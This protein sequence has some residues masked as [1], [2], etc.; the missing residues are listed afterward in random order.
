MTPAAL[1]ASDP[2]FARDPFPTYAEL[3]ARGPVGCVPLSNG[4]EAW[5]VTGLAEAR[6]VLAD[7]R[8]SAVRPSSLDSSSPRGVLERPMLNTDAPEHTRLRRLASRAFTEARIDALAPRIEVLV[9]ALLDAIPT[10]GVVDIVSAFGFPLPVQVMCEVLGVPEADRLALRQ[11]TYTVASP[12]GP[13]TDDAWDGLLTY[14]TGLIAAKRADPTDDVFSDLVHL[15]DDEGMLTEQELVAMA[16]LLLFAGYETTMNLVGSAVLSLLTHPDQL[17]ALTTP[18]LWDVAVEELLR[19]GSPLEGATWR[20][21]TT[22]VEVAGVVV[23]EGSSV[24]VVLGAANRDPDRFDDP[25]L[26]DLTRS[27]N[28]HLAFGYGPHFCIG[29]RLA[30]LEATIALARLVARFPHVRLVADPAGIAWRPGLLVRGPMRL[31]VRLDDPHAHLHSHADARRAAGLRRRLTARQADAVVIDLAG[32]DYLGLT[33]DP[34]VIDGAVTAASTWG[35]GATGSRLVTGSTQGHHD[36]ED[37]LAAFVGAEAGLVLSSGYLANLGAVA[38]LSGPGALVISEAQNH[39][40]IIDACRLSRADVVVTEHRDIAAVEL[41]LAGRT[42]E[43]A[44]V[45]T[46]AVFSVDGDLAPLTELAYACRR[47]GAL[48]IID[49][50]HALGVVGDGGRGA[51]YAAGLSGAPDI[52]L[53]ATLSKALGSQGGVVLGS[54]AVIDHLVDTARP[55]I[56]DTGL[57]PAAVGAAHSALDAL[58]ADPTLPLRARQRARDLARVARSAGWTAS[59]PDAAV[60]SILIGDPTLAVAAAAACLARG[61]RVGC[62]RP[63]SVPDAISRLRLTARADLTESDIDTIATV[64]AEVRAEVLA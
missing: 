57:A 63:P 10:T 45:V 56:F 35:G 60:T 29:G 43:R 23:P 53:T 47:H 4:R 20:W 54:R 18:A 41:A 44:I 8:F 59:E 3:R 26:L 9:D 11:W 27:P 2:A 1:D 31:D 16:F 14:F 55:F 37:A 24:L 12:T 15:T 39:A 38:A 61:V 33:R 64:L 40:S 5:F 51:T 34:R 21:A 50:A 48:L 30:R 36:L 7:K 32:N 52:V 42:L 17:R 25:D 19:H 22:D 13:G 49:E 62:F 6:Y 28:P 46:D 58:V